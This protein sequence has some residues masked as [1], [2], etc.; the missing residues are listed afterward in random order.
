[1]AEG[2][3]SIIVVRICAAI[4]VKLNSKQK[5]R[6]LFFDRIGF[7]RSPSLGGAGCSR[8]V[9]GVRGALPGLFCRSGM[10]E[11]NTFSSSR[12]DGMWCVRTEK[13]KKEDTRV[14]L[15]VETR[16]D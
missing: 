15:C 4:I 7:S 2:F 12:H 16:R 1:M 11:P 10:W 9:A 3:S 5:N 8:H 6:Y 13:R 14:I